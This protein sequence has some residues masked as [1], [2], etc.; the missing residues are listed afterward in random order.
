MQIRINTIYYEDFI[1]I[2]DFRAG[3][4]AWLAFKDKHHIASSE[5][6]RGCGDI[7]ENDVVVAR[8]SYNGRVW[9][10]IE[11]VWSNKNKEILV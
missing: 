10:T 9:E 8:V 6:K 2:S 4:T 5:M 1:N 11:E 3:V 7:Y